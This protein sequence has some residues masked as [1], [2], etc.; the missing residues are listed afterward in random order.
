M[1]SA[2]YT[3]EKSA[4]GRVASLFVFLT[5]MPKPHRIFLPAIYEEHMR[6]LYAGLDDSRDMVLSADKIN[7]DLPTK[8]DM[9]YF[10]FAQVGRICVWEAGRE[11]EA[12][13]SLHEKEALDK[14]AVMLQAALNLS[15]P[16]VG[17]EVDLLRERGYFFC[18][19]LPR[20]LDADALLMTKIIHRPYWEDIQLYLDRSKR[21][22]DVVKKDWE[23]AVD[24]R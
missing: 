8:I 5:L 21:L 1:P 23:R 15:E 19:I 3:T 14:G 10:A 9:Q 6:Y 24:K 7:D 13:F 12:V 18:G 2:A 17:C 4:P 22:L 16:W 11:F 20:W